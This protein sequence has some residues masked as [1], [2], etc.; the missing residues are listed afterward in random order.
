MMGM[1]KINWSQYSGIMPRGAINQLV[2][3]DFES[4]D[5]EMWQDL[6]TGY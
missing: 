2:I 1:Y 3:D 5:S 6:P 4:I